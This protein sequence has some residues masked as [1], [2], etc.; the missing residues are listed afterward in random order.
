[1]SQ[2]SPSSG[3]IHN[4][5]LDL[6]GLDTFNDYAGA[7][8][9]NFI[10]VAFGNQTANSFPPNENGTLYLAKTNV[11]SLGND[12][13]VCNTPGTEFPDLRGLSGDL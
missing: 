3:D 10:Y 5:T 13:Q 12:F 11:I 8:S 6:S 2:G 4:I 1:M 7:G 9:G